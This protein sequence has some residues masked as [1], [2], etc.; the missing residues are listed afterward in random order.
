MNTLYDL[1]GIR[2]DADDET[3][4]RAFHEAVKATHPDLPADDTDALLRFWQIV[5]ANG[6]L[7]DAKQRAVYSRL[8]EWERQRLRSKWKRIIISEAIAVAVLTVALVGGYALF[9]PIPTTAVVAVKTDDDTS[10]AGAAFKTDDDTSIAGV[11]VKKDDDTSIAVA[12]VKKDDDTSIAV[13]A[14]KKDDDTSIAVVPTAPPFQ[15]RRP[16]DT[17]IRQAEP[18]PS[19]PGRESDDAPNEA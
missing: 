15:E 2:P 4:K 7:H 11:A 12:A 5:V 10:T 19:G 8:L 9:A 6:I 13:A 16:N 1:L 18:L 14:V 17:S 3:L